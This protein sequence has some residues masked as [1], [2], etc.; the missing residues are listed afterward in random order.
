ML[1]S[2]RTMIPFVVIGV[3]FAQTA[4]SADTSNPP[5]PAP[6]VLKNLQVLPKNIK[7]DEL[8]S[9][10]DGF[11]FGLGVD[12]KFCH[13]PAR[14]AAGKSLPPGADPLDYSLDDKAT[15]R[16]ARQMIIM[17]RTVNAMIPAAVGK[18]A[19]KAISIKCFNC[20]RGLATPPLP[21]ADVLSRTTAEKGL[22]AAIAQYR[23]LRNR[24]YYS[25]AY[26]F[27][28]ATVGQGASRGLPAYAFQLLNENK[29]DESVAWSKVNL[30]YYPKSAPS[31]ATIGFVAT[32][33]HDRA[34]ALKNLQK[35]ISLEPDPQI[36]KDLLKAAEALPP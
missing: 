32:Q 13:A 20:H 2:L 29:L 7:L 3:Y 5:A 25:G 34:N 26:D 9:T 4:M 14:L 23:E 10:M 27:S 28:D 6:M 19:D 35:A 8:M 31:Y 16:T 24:S 36:L 1:V 18:P 11:T 30:E 33:K 12:C 15:K 22:A 17:L 21:L